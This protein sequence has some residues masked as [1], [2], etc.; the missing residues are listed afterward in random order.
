M[1]PEW[2]EGFLEEVAFQLGGSYRETDMEADDQGESH[3]Y[4]NKERHRTGQCSEAGG[5]FA[6]AGP[7]MRPEAQ[8]AL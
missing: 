2:A 4:G 7:E 1:R 5:G 3:S 8:R 6:V